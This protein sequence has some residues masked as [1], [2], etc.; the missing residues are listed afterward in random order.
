MQEEAKEKEKT[1]N[2][3]KILCLISRKKRR[4]ICKTAL[5]SLTFTDIKA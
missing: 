3:Y 5:I 1:L 4:T 2:L